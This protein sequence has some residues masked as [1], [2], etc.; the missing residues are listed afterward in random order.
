MGIPW[1]PSEF[2]QRASAAGHP[3]N[4]VDGVPDALATVIRKNSSKSPAT[5]GQERTAMIRRWVSRANDLLDDETAFKQAL[6]SHCGRVLAKNRL[7]VF[8]E[9]LHASSHGDTSLVGL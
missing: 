5:L 1:T 7:L 3:N 2:V 8:K 6:P 4:I 9:M